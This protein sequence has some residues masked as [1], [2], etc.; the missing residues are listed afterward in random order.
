MPNFMIAYH[1]GNEPASQEEGLAQM[2][3]WK[4]WVAGL[5]ETI[6]NP[7]TPL[8]QSKLVTSAGVNEDTN[9]DAMKGFAVV[10]AESMDDA[11]KIAQ[12]DLFLQ[13]D[14]TIHVSQMM[15]MP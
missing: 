3:K 5:G 2:Q 9:P 13:N 12:S 10:N 14:G 6:V 15:E 7:G 1:G 8:P 4:E 11:I